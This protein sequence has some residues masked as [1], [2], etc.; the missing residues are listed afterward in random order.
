MSKLTAFEAIVGAGECLPFLQAQELLP[1]L[2]IVNPISVIFIPFRAMRAPWLEGSG[3]KSVPS[4]L[5]L[6][7]QTV[8]LLV[9]Q[10]HP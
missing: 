10:E 3:G 9:A 5:L 6:F 8:G 2:S 7:P 4:T 1:T